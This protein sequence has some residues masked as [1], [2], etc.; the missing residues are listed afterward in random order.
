MSFFKLWYKSTEKQ[1]FTYLS[2]CICS[3]VTFHLKIK[4]GR[5]CA[6]NADQMHLV[7]WKRN[8][9]NEQRE[10]ILKR[11]HHACTV[12]APFSSMGPPFPLGQSQTTHMHQH[13]LTPTT[14]L[15]LLETCYSPIGTQTMLNILGKKEHTKAANLRGCGGDGQWASPK[16]SH[17]KPSTA[18][19]SVLVKCKALQHLASVSVHPS[20][21]Q[22][23][24]RNSQPHRLLQW[25]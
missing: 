2:C 15:D 25:V 7:C 14:A 11:I 13:P 12:L 22:W 8:I 1:K 23:C 6:H 10:L 20:S 21:K 4:L 24:L 3:W 16:G 17:E 5:Q 18:S 19:T 9:L